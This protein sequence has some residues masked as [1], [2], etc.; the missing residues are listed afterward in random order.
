MSVYIT[1]AHGKNNEAVYSLSCLVKHINE[2][3]TKPSCFPIQS[4]VFHTDQLILH[5]MVSSI[6]AVTVFPARW[7]SRFAGT[8]F[9]AGWSADDSILLTRSVAAGTQI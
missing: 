6:F 8:V 9:P 4:V 3:G 1:V 7:S 5:P 2:A